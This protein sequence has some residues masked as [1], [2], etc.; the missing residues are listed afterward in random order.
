MADFTEMFV[1][2]VLFMASLILVDCVLI[3]RDV[4]K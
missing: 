4:R 3:W 2:W 1:V